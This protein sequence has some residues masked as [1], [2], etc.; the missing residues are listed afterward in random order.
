MTYHGTGIFYYNSKD[1][2]DGNWVYGL[3]HGKGIV[4]LGGR[5][6]QGNW[7]NGFLRCNKEVVDGIGGMIVGGCAGVCSIRGLKRM[8]RKMKY[9][10]RNQIR[11]EEENKVKSSVLKVY[12]N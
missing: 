10:K 2:L 4:V 3:P 9:G 7:K 12:N 5:T 8:K 1:R 6:L 11:E